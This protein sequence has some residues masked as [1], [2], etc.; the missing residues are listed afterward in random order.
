M[1]AL[2]RVLAGAVVRVAGVHPSFSSHN[3]ARWYLGRSDRLDLEQFLAMSIFN[4]VLTRCCQTLWPVL[5]NFN[6]EYNACYPAL[7]FPAQGL[8]LFQLHSTTP[9]SKQFSIRMALAPKF[10][11]QAYSANVSPKAIHTVRTRKTR[12]GS[13]SSSAHEACLAALISFMKKQC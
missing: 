13:L 6:V 1:A 5:S 11:G 4:Q 3:S 8:L 7:A 9:Q 12:S 2:R 10:A